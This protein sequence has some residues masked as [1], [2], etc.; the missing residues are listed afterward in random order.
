MATQAEAFGRVGKVAEQEQARTRKGAGPD[1]YRVRPLPFED[2]YLF[3]KRIDNSGVVRLPNR[4]AQR[5]C[6]RALILG[7]AL[8]V[9]VLAMFYPRFYN[10]SVGYELSRERMLRQ[11]LLEERSALEVAEARLVGPERLRRLAPALEL[12]EPPPSELVHLNPA[13]ESTSLALNT[14]PK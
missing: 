14:G 12:G 4:A 9:L 6:L 1:P 10:I 2:L 7:G 11:K 13:G 3:R 5:R 8:V